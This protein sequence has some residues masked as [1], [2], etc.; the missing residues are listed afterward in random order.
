[1]NNKDG[2]RGGEDDDGG[3]D[4]GRGERRMKMGREG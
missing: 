2:R 1:M 4:D 3:D